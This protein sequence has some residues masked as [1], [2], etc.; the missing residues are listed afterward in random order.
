MKPRSLKRLLVLTI[1]F[2]F[3]SGL[4]VTPSMAEEKVKT[5]GKMVLSKKGQ[6]SL[7]VDDAKEHH[8]FLF[9]YL[10]T[11]L[12]TGKNEFM[13]CAEAVNRYFADFTE[14]NGPIQGY[15][16]LSKKGDCVLVKWSGEMT[17]YSADAT[18]VMNFVGSYS[19]VKGTGQYAN[20]EGK[21][22]FRGQMFSWIIQI[23]EW[24]G[25]YTI[26]K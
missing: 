25:E 17:A 13:D 12:S 10:G 16:K 8:L 11:N 24:E 4:G 18:V 26:K 1:A 5:A 22:T 23:V 19:I 20:I 7:R 2:V 14:R 9:D 21:G 15:T 6:E 3:L